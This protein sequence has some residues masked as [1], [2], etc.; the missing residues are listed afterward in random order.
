MTKEINFIMHNVNTEHTYTQAYKWIDAV[1][2][3][4]S[5]EQSYSVCT[6]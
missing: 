6:S 4:S 3:G 5:S 2:G 1:N